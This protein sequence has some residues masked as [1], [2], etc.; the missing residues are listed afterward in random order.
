M[1]KKF[2]NS[3]IISSLLWVSFEKFGYSV[4]QF[5][6]TLV[7]AR[8]LTPEDFGIIGTVYILISL[9]QMV[10]QSGLG[11]ALV[12]KKDVTSIDYNTVF[13][14][15]IGCSVMLYLILFFTAPLIATFYNNLVL[16]PVIRVI[17][18]TVIISSLTLI[19]R[20]HLL[21]SLDFKK[22]SI[23][24]NV[25][26][27]IAICISIVL[28]LY[29]FGVWALV[30]QQL[31]YRVFYLFAIFYFVKFKPKILFSVRS[32]KSLYGF[33]V[34]LF[35]ASFLDILYKDG[36]TSFI[37]KFY[38]ILITGYFY[39]AK[40]L[41]DFP[42]SIYR[43]FGDN[44]VFAMLCRENDEIEFAKKSSVFMRIILVLS[45]PLFIII[46]LLSDEL[47][48]LLLGKQWV[49]S[50]LM[51]SVLCLGALGLIIDSVSKNILKATGNGNAIISSEIVKKIF[52]VLII[53]VFISYDF[54]L[55]LYSLVIINLLGCIVNMYYVSRNTEYHYKWQVKDILPIILLTVFTFALAYL[56][57]ITIEVNIFVKVIIVSFFVLL[58]YFT[59]SYLF[60]L[61]K[62]DLKS[63][64]SEKNNEN[65][66][67]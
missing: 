26:F 45:M 22:Q 21:R 38:S 57:M 29:D 7:L 37:A 40:K 67:L 55:L 33:G 64:K 62:S 56:I 27:L 23:I 35:G 60:L 43:A 19:Q 17:T 6:A 10:V 31:L 2:L 3:K 58:F 52:A 42:V 34:K 46:Y 44:V 63:I 65:F 5:I 50:S 39:Q 49:E 24:S 8:L 11:M 59:L 1:F 47:V 53:G 30:L 41:I 18:L 28:A 61:N 36:L 48:I 51:L 12:N 9:S 14:F 32:F 4:I 15:N 66:I 20:V 25:S 13:T 16:I 54:I